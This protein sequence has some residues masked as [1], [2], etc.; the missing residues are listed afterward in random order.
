[1][2]IGIDARF[3]GILGKGLGRYTQQLIEHLEKIDTENTY[4]I[5]LRKEN[6]LEYVPQNRNFSK[7]LADIPWY[8]FREQ[9]EFPLLLRKY[10]LD[11]VHF[12][13]FNVPI[14]YRKPFVVTIHDLILLHHSTHKG[15]TLPR[16]LYKIK[17]FV[18]KKILH[19]AMKK[20]KHIL[21]VSQFTKKDILEN[22]P[23][24]LEEKISVSYEANTRFPSL[25]KEKG[26]TVR[27]MNQYGIIKPYF[28]YVGNAYP[29]K[30][31]FLML[32]AFLSLQRED[33]VFV[34]VGKIDVFYSQLQGS[35]SK[36]REQK[37]IIFVGEVGDD[38]LEVL[39]KNA[40]VYVFVS[41]YEGFGLPPLEAMAHG[42]PVV[43]SCTTSMPE[44]LG[45]APLYCDPEKENSIKQSLLCMIEQKKVRD[46]CRRRGF[47]Q[48]EM[49]NWEHLAEQTIRV[50]KQIFFQN[51]P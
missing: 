47:R 44:I 1:M 6:F 36:E 14:L 29:H 5:F 38:E 13:H 3:Y 32:K 16:F 19:Y 15:S 11:L 45:K 43:S 23:F 37:K 25:K 33:F 17:F 34:L 49:Y 21:T 12:P 39:Y 51:K 41:L 48:V 31:L 18:Y 40:F 20:A 2:R 22:Y 35:F 9:W 50:Y 26:R 42:I 24:I 27:T 28:L 4:S 46:R 30:N 8:G 7:I 10:D